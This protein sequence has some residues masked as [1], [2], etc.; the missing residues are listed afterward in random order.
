MPH[1]SNTMILEC[2]ESE[3]EQSADGQLAQISV[4]DVFVFDIYNTYDYTDIVFHNKSTN[5]FYRMTDSDNIVDSVIEAIEILCNCEFEYTISDI[6]TFIPPS[7]QPERHLKYDTQSIHE[8]KWTD[9]YAC[10]G[11]VQFNVC[12]L[13]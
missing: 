3:F 12:L 7:N 8:R 11:G 9:L 4:N 2:S 10:R 6:A 5:K 1:R 13:S